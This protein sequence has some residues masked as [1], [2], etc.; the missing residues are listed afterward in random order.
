VCVVCVCDSCLCVCVVYLCGVCGVLV[1][2]CVC[3]LEVVN[4]MWFRVCVC[5]NVWMC[6]VWC[7]GMCRVYVCVSVCVCLV[8]VCGFVCVLCV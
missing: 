7:V 4:V 2:P 5:V 8:C 3:G 6:G 1:R